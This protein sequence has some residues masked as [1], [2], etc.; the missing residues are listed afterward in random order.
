MNLSP[1][2]KVHDLLSV[3]PFLKDV[4]VALDPHFAALDNPVLRRTLGRMATLSRAAMIGGVDINLMLGTLANEIKKQTGETVEVEGGE[5]AGRAQRIEILKGIIRELHEGGDLAQLRQRFLTLIRDVAPTEIAQ[6][7]QQLINEGMPETEVKRLCDVHVDVFRQS[8]DHRTVPGL[9]AGHPVHTYMLENR[10]LETI[11]DQL[12]LIH[13]LARERTTLVGLLNGI[14]EVDR[15]YARKENQLFPL[16]EAR[17]ISGPSKVMWS[18]HDDIRRMIRDAQKAAE[19]GAPSAEALRTLVRALHDMIYKEEHILYPM[20]LETLGDSDWVRVRSGEEEIGY[21]WI[22][23]AADWSPAGDGFHEK[24]PPEKVGAITL[25]TGLLTVEQMNLILTRLPVDVSFV[26][27]ND[28][29]AYYS[30]T[31]DRIFP[32]SPGIIGRKVQN[33][34]PPKSVDMVEKILEEFKAGRKDDAE[35]WIQMKGKFIHIRYFAVRD[36]QGHYRG[37]L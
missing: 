17:G 25:D 34:H 13:D 6:M 31:A 28:Q 30:N 3:Y 1:K 29:V 4:L 20:A 24:L 16:L 33:C 7:E 36:G 18:L 32:R 23:P 9:P 35:F 19:S 5:E 10:S 12:S 11:L 27:E 2:T 21:A 14:A 37:T 8:L 15:H 26:D 22:R